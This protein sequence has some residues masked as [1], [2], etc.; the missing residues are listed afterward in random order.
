MLASPRTLTFVRLSSQLILNILRKDDV[1]IKTEGSISLGTVSTVKGSDS[2]LLLLSTVADIL[3]CRS[4]RMLRYF[5]WHVC[6]APG[7]TETLAV[8]VG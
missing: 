7:W 5:S 1:N 6:C 8:T 3:L 2:V 4:L